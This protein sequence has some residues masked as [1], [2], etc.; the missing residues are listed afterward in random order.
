[1]ASSDASLPSL[2]AI[3]R[4]KRQ[5]ACS[6]FQGELT[7]RL[8]HIDCMVGQILCGLALLLPT[9][10]LEKAAHPESPPGLDLNLHA[11]YYDIGE[12]HIDAMVQTESSEPQENLNAVVEDDCDVSQSACQIERGMEDTDGVQAARHNDECC[13][14][15]VEKLQSVQLTSTLDTTSTSECF[16]PTIGDW[17]EFQE[18]TLFL[19]STSSSTCSSSDDLHAEIGHAL[20][21]GLRVQDRVRALKNVRCI[22]EPITLLT[23]ELYTFLGFDE[24]TARMEYSHEDMTRVFKVRRR[25]ARN[26]ENIK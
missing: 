2:S 14:T 22:D 6:A 3:R 7:R 20:P 8:D 4:H 19:H 13:E 12:H 23:G 17:E 11:E 16:D 5:A 24:E 21:N 1:M 25:D 15:N 10:S 26:F 9:P 18:A